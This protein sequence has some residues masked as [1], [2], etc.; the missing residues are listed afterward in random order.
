MNFQ[1][2]CPPIPCLPSPSSLSLIPF[3]FSFFLTPSSLLS[4]FRQIYP[5]SKMDPPYLYP[6]WR[7]SSHSFL[8]QLLVWRNKNAAFSF[9]CLP[10]HQSVSGRKPHDKIGHARAI[11]A[12][13]SRHPACWSGP[14]IRKEGTVLIHDMGQRLGRG[15]FYLFPKTNLPLHPHICGSVQESTIIPQICGRRHLFLYS[16]S[17]KRFNL[18][19]L[20]TRM[21]N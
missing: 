20:S 4:P 14:G 2:P 13:P 8:F 1:G 19:Y 17:Q 5:R 12:R 18:C 7:G 9:P 16:F 3:S 21:E 6:H 10:L 15:P 11:C